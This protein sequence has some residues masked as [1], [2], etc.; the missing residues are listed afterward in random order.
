MRV[1]IIRR[2]LL[3]MPVILGI[4]IFVFALTRMGGDPA[5]IYYT[6]HMNQAARADVREMLH[7]NEDILTQYWYWL[8]EIV[9]GNWGY[10]PTGATSVTE[11]IAL[12]FPATFEL[13]I[14]A[15]VIALP[16][17]IYL[18]TLSAV[19]R[20]KTIDHG[21]RIFALIGVS[22]PI[23]VLGLVLQYIF[24][25][26]LQI[27]PATGRYDEILFFD[28]QS[29][30][31]NY[32]GF[33]L[34]DCILNMNWTMF[35]D[36][37]KHLILPAVTLSLGSI[38]LIARLMRSSMLEVLGLDYVKSARAKGLPERVVIKKHARRNALIPVTTVGGLMFG[39][40]LGGAVITE[41][42]Y[43]WPGLGRWA[44]QAITTFD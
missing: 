16:T 38:A 9:Q 36:G 28:Y 43:S 15:L 41:T 19:K 3:L 5:A 20:G 4:T 25:F 11:S 10:S 17:G 2:L 39:G 21:T 32:T 37:F 31:H 26:K 22:L 24:Y 33:F 13:A 40:M 30:F 6:P 34:I 42:I 44:T 8:S 27:L 14:V 1:F 29:S 18:G 35:V 23:F 12:F 7:L